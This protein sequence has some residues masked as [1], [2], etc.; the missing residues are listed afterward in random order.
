M[1]FEIKLEPV[2]IAPALKANL[3]KHKQRI[4]GAL[5]RASQKLADNI[6]AEGRSDISGAGRF[7][8]RWTTGF[9][10]DIAGA[11]LER[12]ITFRH[13]VPYWRVFQFGAVIKGRPLLWIP[14]PGVD[15]GERGDFFATSKKGNLLLFKKEGRDIRPLRVAKE[16][17]RIPKKFHLVEIIVA[18][19]KT[20]GALF[21]LEVSKS[22]GG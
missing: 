8:P 11:E 14:L 12:T 21:R 3:D 13:A 10:Y 7:G 2:S 6:L 1:T 18:E 19:S 16:S 9:T 20:L 5:V 22:S 17:V 4:Q 15:P